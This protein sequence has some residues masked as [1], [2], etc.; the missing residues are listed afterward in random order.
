M[1]DWSRLPIELKRADL[2]ADA[3]GFFRSMSYFLPESGPA[4][5]WKST[6]GTLAGG[7]IPAN[8][9]VVVQG[10]VAGELTLEH[11]VA[12]L[13]RGHLRGRI[14]TG[15]SCEVVVAGD[16]TVGGGTTGEVSLFV[17]NDMAGSLQTDGCSTVWVCGHLTGDVRTGHPMTRT[18]VRGDCS[19]SFR[20]NSKRGMLRLDVAGYMPSA[21]VEQIAMS[22]YT[23]FDASIGVS[24]RVAGLY[25]SL[26][27]HQALARRR[28]YVRWVIHRMRD[29]LSSEGP[30]ATS[31]GSG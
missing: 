20:P 19:G 3:F 16:V 12:L 4:L 8:D 25:P 7:V 5:A 27:Q 21:V 30:A 31:T 24:D 17:G 2:A 15:G 22:R 28:S 10:D 9:R 18:W 6:H 14:Q 13:I 23:M 29:A 1:L 11:D 26:K